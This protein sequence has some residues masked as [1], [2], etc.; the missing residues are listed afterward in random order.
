MERQKGLLIVAKLDYLQSRL[1]QRIFFI[2]SK[3]LGKVGKWISEV[4]AFFLNCFAA[5]IIM[6]T[7]SRFLNL[8]SFV[9]LL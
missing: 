6:Y 9:A 4:M 5:V 8:L 2:I 3:P 1:L 7:M